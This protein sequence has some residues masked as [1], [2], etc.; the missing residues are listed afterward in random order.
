M[1]Q[2]LGISGSG[3]TTLVQGFG[4]LWICAMTGGCGGWLGKGSMLC[5]L[6]GNV[7]GRI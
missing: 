4:N 5:M 3:S 7:I 6:A 2:Y 1:V